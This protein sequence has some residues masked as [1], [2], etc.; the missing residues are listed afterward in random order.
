MHHVKQVAV[1]SD[2]LE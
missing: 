1:P 2:Y